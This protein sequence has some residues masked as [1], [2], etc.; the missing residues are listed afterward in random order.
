MNKGRRG[1]VVL[2]FQKSDKLT[3][4]ADYREQVRLTHK[5]REK[6]QEMDN[7]QSVL[8]F[9]LYLNLLFCLPVNVSEWTA[10]SN[11]YITV[12]HCTQLSVAFI[13]TFLLCVCVGGWGCAVCVCVGV[14]ILYTLMILPRRSIF[15]VRSKILLSLGDGLIFTC[16]N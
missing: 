5:R 15:T 2:H 3:N 6:T 10:L 7:T 13:K 1:L 11:S 9:S 4:K 14:Y 12:K 16:T 8:S